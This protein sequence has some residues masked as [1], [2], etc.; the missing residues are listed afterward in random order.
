[1]LAALAMVRVAAGKTARGSGWTLAAPEGPSGGTAAVGAAALGT[2]YT[3]PWL[4]LGAP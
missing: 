2:S 1:M 3:S 4:G